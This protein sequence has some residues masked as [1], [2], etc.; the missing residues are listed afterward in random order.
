MA[1]PQAIEAV[2]PPRSFSPFAALLSY[3]IPGLGQIWQGRI[4]KG[5]LFFVCINVLFFYGMYLGHWSNVYM[6]DETRNLPRITLFNVGG[7][8]I[9]LSGHAA[10]I[11]HRPHFA[12]QFWMGMAVWPAIVQYAY[13]NVNDERPIPLLGSFQRQPSEDD[14]DDPWSLNNL[15]RRGDKTWDLGWVYT[16]IA[17][18]LNLLV[19]YDALTGPALAVVADPTK[20]KPE[21]KAA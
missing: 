1:Q 8:P 3:L 16:V 12:A 20:T 18:L 14:H 2:A 10:S 19:I 6:V 15:Q 11:G 7:R 5:V 13:Y 4:G 17:G 9:E 21:E